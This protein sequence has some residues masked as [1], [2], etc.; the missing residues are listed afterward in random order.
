MNLPEFPTR[1]N[2]NPDKTH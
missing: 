2:V 1:R